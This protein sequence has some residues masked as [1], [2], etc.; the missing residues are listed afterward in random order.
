MKSQNF[1]EFICFDLQKLG[2]REDEKFVK[3]GSET[4]IVD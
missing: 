1:L 4:G 3:H 2:D